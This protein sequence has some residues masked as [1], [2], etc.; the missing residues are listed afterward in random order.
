MRLTASL[1]IINILNTFK[2]NKGSNISKEIS[3]FFITPPLIPAL[4]TT[5]FTGPNFLSI[6]LNSSIML[7]S[8]LISFLIESA[9]PPEF[10]I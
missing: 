1:I 5:A 6:K 9:E 8:E 10:L 4:L 7:S 3:S 2:R